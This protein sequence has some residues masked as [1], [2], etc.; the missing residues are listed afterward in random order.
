[1]HGL[2]AGNIIQIAFFWELTSLASFLLIGSALMSGL[3]A[4]QR[5]PKE[6]RDEQAHREAPT[7][8]SRT[9]S[10]RS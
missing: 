6:L 9:H 8:V 4:W 7:L 1:M 3:E 2:T 10:H 5:Q